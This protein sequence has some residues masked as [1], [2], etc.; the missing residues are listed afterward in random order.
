MIKRI[1]IVTSKYLRGQNL[2]KSIQDAPYSRNLIGYHGNTIHPHWPNGARIA[3]QL[4]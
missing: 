4:I 1:P 3:L 2:I